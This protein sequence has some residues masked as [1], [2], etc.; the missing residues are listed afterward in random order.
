MNKNLKLII[1]SVWG[2]INA[3]TLRKILSSILVFLI[4][5]TSIRFIFLKP[6]EVYADSLVGFN[7][8]YGTTVNDNSGNISG[9]IT[10]AQWKSEEFCKVGKCLYFD[11]TG[12]Y[13]SFGDDSDLDFAAATNFTIEGWFRTPD[14]TSGQRTLVAKHNAT[15]GGYKL[16]IDSNGYVIFG[17]DD[18]LTWTPDDSVSTTATAFDDNKWHH[19]AAVKTG[20]TSISLY[21][22]GIL[23]QTDSSIAATGTLVNGD[24]FY[25][26]IDGNGSSNGFSGFLDEIKIYT[27]SA[28]TQAQINA[29]KLG[30][31]PSR[32]TS[33][34]FGPDQSYLSHGLVGYW[35]MDESSSGSNATDSSGN[36]NS[37]TNNG[38]TP[39]ASGKYGNA[40]G[41]FNGTTRYFSTTASLPV[42]TVSFWAYP[43][44]TTNNYFNLA[45]GKYLTSSSGTL[46]ATG[47]TNATIYVDGVQTTTISANTWQ[48]ITVTD[49]NSITADT[50]RF[51]QANGSYYASGGYLDEF[52]LYN[53]VLSNLEI[54]KLYLWAPG[55]VGYW[56]F[57]ESSGNSNDSSGNNN[58]LTNQNSTTYTAGKFGSAIDVESANSNYFSVNDNATLSV[59]SSLTLSG[60]IKPESVTATTRFGIASKGNDYALIQYGDEIR[61]YVGSTSNYK[62]T[63]AAN[64]SA[65][66]WYHVSAVYSA[67][68]QTVT[69]YVN[70]IE[71]AGTTTGTIPPSISD[72]T[73]SFGIGIYS[74]GSSGNV[75]RSVAASTD[76]ANVSFGGDCNSSAADTNDTVLLFGQVGIATETCSGA[77][78]TNITIPNA[79]TITS[80]SFSATCSGAYSTGSTLAVKVAAEAT[81]NASAFSTS[82]TNL[83]TTARPRTSYTTS[84]DWSSCASSSDT[85]SKDVTSQVQA[86]INRAGWASGNALAILIDNNGSANDEWQEPWSFDGSGQ[87]PQISIDYTSSTA[88]YYDGIIDD[89]KIYNYTRTSSQVTEDMNAGHPAPGSPVGS[90]IA[91]WR[92]DEGALNTCS[93]GTNDFCDAS[94]NGNDL[95]FSTA[96][97]GYTNSGKFGKA[98]DGTGAFWVSRADDADF[99]ISATDDYTISLWYKADNATN[100][101]T[102]EYLLNKAGATTAGYSV[103]ANSSDQLCFGIDDDTSWGP[104]IASCTTDDQYG[105]TWKHLVA[106]RDYTNTDKAYI[107]IDGVLKDSDSDTTTATL[108][109][110]LPLYL[111]DR[112]GTNNGDEFTGDLDEVQIFR[113]ALTADQVKLLYNQGSMAVMG[114]T[115]TDSSGNASWSANDEYCPPGQGSSCTGPYAE[116]KFDENT[117]TTAYDSSGNGNNGTLHNTA[118]F[119]PGKLGSAIYFDGS[120]AGNDTHV[121]LPDGAFNS[122]SQGTVSA[123]FKSNLD[124][125]A[126]DF[127]NILVLYETGG[128]TFW[129]FAYQVS[130][131]TIEIYADGSGC[132]TQ[133]GSFTGPKTAAGWHH[134]AFTVDGST[135]KVYVD[136]IESTRTGGSA[137]NTCF[138]DNYA[139]FGT[140]N[141]AIGC[142][143]FGAAPACNADEMWRGYIDNVRIYDYARTPAQIAWEYNR[144]KPVLWWKFD[145]GT[146]TTANDSAGFSNSGTL[147]SSSWSTG[148]INTAWN[149]TGALWVSRSNNSDLDFGASDSFSVSGWF[150]SDSATNPANG[151]EYIVSTSAGNTIAGYQVYAKTDGTVCFGIDDDGTWT[152]IESCTA[153]DF[154]DGTW[155]F[156]TAVR[157]VTDDTTNI[158]IDGKLM[159][160]DTDPTTATL[161]GN[162]AFYVGDFDGDNNATSGIEEFAGDIDD[163]RVFRYALTQKQIQ[164]IMNE[165]GATRFGPNE[166][167]S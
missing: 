105:T 52:R 63:D 134:V 159:D 88:Y 129:E 75:S 32:G 142:Y 135:N 49:T 26:G 73:D 163:V 103:Y 29:D 122:L 68:A 1:K 130:T 89:L 58:A 101:S 167:S 10:N 19:F 147:S 164:L 28:R 92:F 99:D 106:V 149:G 98:F 79:A 145:E 102:T 119:A 66:T 33:T 156:F 91:K 7:E 42:Q 153:N 108:A 27:S 127:Q 25:I 83:S 4:L 43:A 158:Y 46:S 114:A 16:Y 140:E 69:I 2:W 5:A 76:D 86:V 94:G 144:G 141:Y 150:K 148:K 81:D 107:Y 40:A 65:N 56:K 54:A 55:P 8:G 15:A 93:G 50:I 110:S 37:L 160:S 64:L 96:T 30:E 125:S 78:F 6:K 82:G 20:T 128:G 118:V 41:T 165:G 100:P 11:G 48:L 35:K 18:D 47:F 9:T 115:S 84:W 67:N 53:R 143:N 24:N 22:D 85:K 124:S 123:W 72:G 61:M 74:E 109:N 70:G 121:Q 71:Q 59:T 138:F 21:V 104:D 131:N 133:T 87:E 38:T 45:S 136:G 34:S 155:H 117:G 14:I 57:D 13:V 139:S 51:G 157:N 80:A 116:Y 95:A 17:V 60:W 31:T 62:T 97:G 151:T 120:T 3:T 126:S 111:A 77:R 146:G 23:Y 12:D 113:S 152:D 90:A 166:G 137:S 44:S 161:D 112:D 132:S 162:G 154:Y 36:G 39:F